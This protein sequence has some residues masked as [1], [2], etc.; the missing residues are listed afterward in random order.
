MP[1]FKHTFKDRALQENA[2]QNRFEAIFMAAGGPPS[3]L[4][5]EQAHQPGVSTH[6]LRLPDAKFVSAFPDFSPA[7]ESELPKKAILL[8][9]HNAE[10]EK[11]FEYGQDG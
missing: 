7:E 1:W 3:M 4:L 8:I 2:I 11:L 9:G 10:F 5:I 6:W